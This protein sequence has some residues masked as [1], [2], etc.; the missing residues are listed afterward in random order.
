[1][2]DEGHLQ[3]PPRIDRVQSEMLMPPAAETVCVLMNVCVKSEAE[4]VAP[5]KLRISPT[6]STRQRRA[7]A[8]CKTSAPSAVRTETRNAEV[9]TLSEWNNNYD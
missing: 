6:D 5:W 7:T 8:S 2:D 1:M 9:R 3:P 4:G